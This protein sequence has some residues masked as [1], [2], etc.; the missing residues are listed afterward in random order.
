MTAQNNRPSL[1]SALNTSSIGKKIVMALTGAALLGFVVLH[2]LGNLQIFLGADAI[3]SYAELLEENAKLVW[4]ARII[5]F[6]IFVTHISFAMNLRKNNKEARPEKYRIDTVV[7]ASSASLYMLE[8]GLVI[9]CFVIIH[10]LHFTFGVLQPQYHEILDSSGRDDIYLMVVNGFSNIYYALGY[11]FA[12][13]ALGFHLSHAIA[14]AC[15]T[16]GFY[17]SYYTLRV[18]RYSRVI[19]YGM[20]I[21]YMSIPISVQLGILS[22]GK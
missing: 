17:H 6:V 18:G 5:L 15:Q 3:N 8:T 12:L 1:L 20:A 21:G 11:C 14:S 9:L 7:Q 10:L 19:G 22:V 2:L 16:L 4:P 13:F